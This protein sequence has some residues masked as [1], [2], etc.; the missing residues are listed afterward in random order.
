MAKLSDAVKALINA[1]HAAP[2][3]TK[4]SPQVLPALKRF[5]EDAQQKQ[6]G[7]PSWVTVSVSHAVSFFIVRASQLAL[8]TC[9]TACKI[10]YAQLY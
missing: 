4:A 2:G 10:Y 7:L 1:S 5:A 9:L 8:A 3:I 6:V